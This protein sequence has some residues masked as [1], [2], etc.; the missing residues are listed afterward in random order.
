MI[1]IMKQ[2][3]FVSTISIVEMLIVF[4]SSFFTVSVPRFISLTFTSGMNLFFNI[5][6][7][8][9]ALLIA[10]PLALILTSSAFS[11]L[12]YVITART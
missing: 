4:P 6:S 12:N 2:N 7:T 8:S 9:T 5:S 3:Y 11:V 1:K 10:L